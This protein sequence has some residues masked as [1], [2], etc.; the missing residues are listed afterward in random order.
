MVLL[1][2]YVVYETNQSTYMRGEGRA[3][4][5]QNAR[6]AL[7]QMTREFL[8][9]G[10]DPTKVLANPGLYNNP[11]GVIIGNYAIQ[12]P[13]AT[14][15]RFLTDSDGD[16]NTE[17]IE[18]AYDAG[19]KR[20][21]RRMGEWNG[22]TWSGWEPANLSIKPITEDNT[23]NSLTFIYRDEANAVTTTDHAVKRIEMSLSATVKVGSQGTQSLDLNS[24]VRPRNL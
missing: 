24:D 22:S 2:L 11:S 10:Y 4:L 23:I 21:T 7:D 3:D 16:N 12:S 8:M 13:G 20:I 14:S 17:V 18:F 15:V 6:V 1:G 19:N 5:Q 9:A